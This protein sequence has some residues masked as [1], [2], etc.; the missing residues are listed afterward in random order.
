M[1][2]ILFSVGPINIYFFGVFLLLAFLLGSFLVWRQGKEEFEEEKIL[3][4]LM[5][6]LL[7]GLFFARLFYILFHF[8]DFGFEILRWFHLV[9]FPGFLFS[10]G[11]LGGVIGLVIYT[12]KAGINF[13]KFADI[14]VFGLAFAQFVGE[15]GN[16]LAGGGVGKVTN[17][18]WGVALLGFVGKRHPLALYEALVAIVLFFVLLRLNKWKINTRWQVA[19]GKTRINPEGISFLTYLACWGFFSFF[20]DFLRQERLFWQGSQT[21]Q[22]FPINQIL[23]LLLFLPAIFIIYFR[24]GRRPKEDLLRLVGFFQGLRRRSHG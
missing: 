16:F 11:L 8:S 22:N 24:L 13:L 19:A 12:K 9:L 15:I 6:A 3:D 10:F 21:S 2:P 23:P 20:L 5:V 7:F 4:G 17:L 14:F 18:P 1:S